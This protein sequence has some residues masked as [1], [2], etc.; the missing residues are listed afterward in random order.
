MERCVVRVL[1]AVPE[2]AAAVSEPADGRGDP[3]LA[4]RRYLSASTTKPEEATQSKRP[5]LSSV[6]GSRFKVQRT[7]YKV[8]GS[9]GKESRG[10]NRFVVRGSSL[11]WESHPIRRERRF[12]VRCESAQDGRDFIYLF[13]RRAG[14]LF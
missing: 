7:K 3:G 11:G 4:S 6:R 2:G 14:E 13:S 1:A 10:E 8:Q 12:V 5:T 9:R